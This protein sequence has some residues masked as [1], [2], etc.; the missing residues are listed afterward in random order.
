MSSDPSGNVLAAVETPNQPPPSQ[1]RRHKRRKAGQKPQAEESE[2]S[3]AAGPPNSSGDIQSLSLFLRLPIEIIG[4]ILR[5]TSSPRDI[6]S[7]ARCS[8]SLCKLLLSES[9]DYIWRDR[10]KFVGL[11]EPTNNFTEASY[12]AFV[13][14]EGECDVS[15]SYP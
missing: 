1:P 10:R 8:K 4:E 3:A 15:Y 2:P 6:L 12:A 7:V 5:Y 13:F 9:A 14:N 11:P